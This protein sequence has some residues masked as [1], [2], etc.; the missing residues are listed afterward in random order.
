MTTLTRS[1]RRLLQLGAA[2]VAAAVAVTVLAALSLGG[3]EERPAP[4]TSGPPAGALEAERL[5]AGVPQDGTTLGNPRAPVTLVEYADLQCPFCGEL[6]RG[7]MP[8]IVRRYVRTGKVR[9]ELRVLRF[10]GPDS[11]RAAD[12]AAAA[13]AQDR[14]F[15]FADLFYRN[16]GTENSGYVTDDFL[17]RLGGAARLDV[18]M[19]MRDRSGDAAAE[20]LGEAESDAHHADIQSTPSLT[21]GRTGGRLE[22]V[23]VGALSAADLSAKLDSLLR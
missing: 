20:L 17:S 23:A 11:M 6:S 18:P 15:Q 10:L 2:V 9:L 13:A 22:I 19:A 21:A 5:Y 3:V 16:Q 1:R 12:F 8:E 7:A 4:E 14:L